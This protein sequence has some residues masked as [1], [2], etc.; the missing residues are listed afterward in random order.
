LGQEEE[1]VTHMKNFKL[2]T[3]ADNPEKSLEEQ[4]RIVAILDKFD[5]LTNSILKVSPR[6]IDY[7]RNNT[8]TTVTCCSV[9]KPDRNELT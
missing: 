8:N 3:Y 5:T 2:P 4:A 1:D 9:S 7:A 6:E